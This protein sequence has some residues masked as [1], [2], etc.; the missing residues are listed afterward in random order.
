[1]ENTS[2]I[3]LSASRYVGLTCSLPAAM[4]VRFVPLSGKLK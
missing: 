4:L 1:M 3:K 2:E